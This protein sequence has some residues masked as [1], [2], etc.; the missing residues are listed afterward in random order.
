MIYCTHCGNSNND[1][2]KFC[3]SCG[4]PSAVVQ[5]IHQDQVNQTAQNPQG[6]QNPQNF[7]NVP[8]ANNN[9]KY[10]FI[11]IIALACV[12]T[13]FFLLRAFGDKD[14]PVPLATNTNIPIEQPATQI[15]APVAEIDP[16]IAAENAARQ[17]VKAV[18]TAKPPVQTTTIVQAPTAT[19]PLTTQSTGSAQTLQ[20]EGS[21]RLNEAELSDI[22]QIMKSYFAADN[23]GDITTLVNQFSY[24]VTRYYDMQG[25]SPEQMENRFS[26]FMDNKLKYHN[27]EPDFGSSQ[28]TKTSNGYQVKVNG[29]YSWETYKTP[30]VIKSKPVSLTFKINQE[31][32]ITSVYE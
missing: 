7:Q 32:K 22:S 19:T 21:D 12:A 29:T 9:L 28:V 10:L 6:F 31:G 14:N 8:P 5:N 1:I 13:V 17:E 26:H 2:A 15:A 18:T 4:K 24:P 16:N 25:A 30:D 20:N 3:A 11:G 23:R 27:L